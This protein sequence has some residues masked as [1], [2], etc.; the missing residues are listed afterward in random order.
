MIRRM[1]T[2][3]LFSDIQIQ[4]LF[5]PLRSW[6]ISSRMQLLRLW[7]SSGMSTANAKVKTRKMISLSQLSVCANQARGHS[8]RGTV[9][10]PDLLGSGKRVGITGCHVGGSDDAENWLVEHD[11]ERRKPLPGKSKNVPLGWKRR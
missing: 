3:E 11:D 2:T 10:R 5:T 6:F 9:F 7:L 1:C 4:L 8:M